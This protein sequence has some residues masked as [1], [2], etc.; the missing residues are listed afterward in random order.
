MEFNKM[1]RNHL[2]QLAAK[3]AITVWNIYATKPLSPKE[4]DQLEIGLDSL[5]PKDFTEVEYTE[6]YDWAEDEPFWDDDSSSRNRK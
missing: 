6:T 1:E 2:I 4:C 5:L 3:N